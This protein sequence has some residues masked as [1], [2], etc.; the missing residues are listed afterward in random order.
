MTNKTNQICRHCGKEKD[1]HYP[2]LFTGRKRY[3]QPPRI[4]QSTPTRFAPIPQQPPQESGLVVA[5]TICPKCEGYVPGHATGSGDI[6]RCEP[7]T[8][9]GVPPQEPEGK[10]EWILA[11]LK[12]P[13]WQEVALK[14]LE[15]L[16][17]QVD[18][19]QARIEEL[20]QRVHL[21]Q[22]GVCHYCNEPVD[23][24]AGNP[25]KWPL[26]FCI[27][28]CNGVA[29]A[30]HSECV[31]E[32]LGELEAAKA[33]IE[34]LERDY[35]NAMNAVQET[36]KDALRTC[37]ER[38][39]FKQKLADAERE[40]EEMVTACRA[41]NTRMEA[42]VDAICDAG[43]G[44]TLEVAEGIKQMHAKLTDAVKALEEVV[45]TWKGH[46]RA[47]AFDEVI[48]KAESALKSLKGEGR[49]TGG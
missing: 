19:K 22:D 30:F 46:F 7:I 33:R 28:G 4:H 25:G 44:N 45:T 36:V 37:E 41:A 10:R 29:K 35:D 15:A 3:C 32:R 42:C 47:K 6:C 1:E 39:Q 18:T 27:A 14:D 43:F 21:K 31:S 48:S 11:N 8:I 34:E 9:Q 23:R 17:Q 12:H 5:G 24:W 2:S 26:V 38:D 40:R 13:L 20:E 16:R 49:G